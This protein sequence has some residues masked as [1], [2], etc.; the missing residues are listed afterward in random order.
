VRSYVLLHGTPLSPQVWDGVRAQ[1][2][3]HT[4]APDLTAMI[5]SVAM[6]RLREEQT[7]PMS[8][9][10]EEQTAPM[11]RLRGEQT[12]PMSG[13]RGEQTAPMSGLREEQWPSG[14]LQAEVAAAVLAAL[15]DGDMVVVGHS[16]GGQV[17]IE[18]ALLAPER[19]ARLVVVCSRH[20]PFPAFAYGART[21]R[22]GRPV[23]I[24][25]G[26]RRWFTPQEV[27]AEGPAVAYARRQL[28]TAPL[29][30]WAASLDA[31]ATYDRASAVGGITAP[32]SL[33]AG[34]LDEVATPAAMAQLAAALPRASLEIV[35]AW[36][37]LS[38][39][40]DPAAFATRLMVAAAVE[41]RM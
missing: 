13:L 22:A 29:G 26:L 9:L 31:A 16:F 34:G 8:R 37:H 36:A 24:D 5:D 12:A 30:P 7:A 20:T 28:Q 32:A 41:P 2:R 19:L 38:P 15:P 3:A 27:A 10:R 11:S 39:F 17:A 25:A 33:F 35:G 21:V 18:L 40:A 1:L 23:D 14:R 4:F 6:S